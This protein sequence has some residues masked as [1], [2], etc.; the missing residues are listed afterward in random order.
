MMLPNQPLAAPPPLTQ[1]SSQPK[2]T[3]GKSISDWAKMIG[4]T[5]PWLTRSGRY[6]RCPP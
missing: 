1:L 3:P 6:C 4:M 5:P 2:S